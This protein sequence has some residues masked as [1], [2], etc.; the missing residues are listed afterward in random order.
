MKTSLFRHE[1][2]YGSIYEHD[3]SAQYKV[4]LEREDHTIVVRKHIE[5]YLRGEA[6]ALP[7]TGDAQFINIQPGETDKSTVYVN[8][9]Y[10]ID[11]PGNYLVQLEFKFGG[12]VI[13]SN[14]ITIT[15]TP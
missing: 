6:E 4:N 14:T 8:N 11:K 9:R 13:K 2:S 3:K 7:G 1:F 12:G 5:S 10:E 15:V